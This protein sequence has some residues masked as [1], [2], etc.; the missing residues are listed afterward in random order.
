M[1]IRPCL[2]PNFGS[3]SALEYVVSTSSMA[4]A[5]QKE[6]ECTTRQAQHVKAD[7]C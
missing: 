4:F 5:V 2:V 7:Q 3:V 6:L 1:S